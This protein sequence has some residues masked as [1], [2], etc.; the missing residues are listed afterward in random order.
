[1]NRWR[2]RNKRWR[3]RGDVRI[4]GRGVEAS[5]CETIANGKHKNNIKAIV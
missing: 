5:G 4:R 2:Y 1:M 3:R